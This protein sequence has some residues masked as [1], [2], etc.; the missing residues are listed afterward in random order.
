MTLNVTVGCFRSALGS[1]Q[2]LIVLTS[3]HP[4]FATTAMLKIQKSATYHSSLQVFPYSEHQDGECEVCRHF[5]TKRKGGRP[6]K[7]KHVP[8]KLCEHMRSCAGLRLRCTYPLTP[9]RFF[10][11]PPGSISIADLQCSIC[12]HIVDEPVE[13]PCKVPLCAE[14][15]I[16]LV[17]KGDIT[18]C[19]SS[20][21]CHDTSTTSFQP[22]SPVLTKLLSHLVL[23]CDCGKPVV[24]RAWRSTSG[25][26]AV[27]S[28]VTVEQIRK[29]LHQSSQP[30]II[31]V[32]TSGHVRCNSYGK[33]MCACVFVC[34]HV[35]VWRV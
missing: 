35:D 32:P 8:R 21:Q 27:A 4:N 22:V 17:Q 11:P 14:C 2:L 24:L 28:T 29:M 31:T 6:R 18:S 13:L 1:T 7:V 10:P 19:P 5:A 20:Q 30:N 25:V 15:C 12:H 16:S 26:A 3:T 34:A 33:C 9:D 23:R